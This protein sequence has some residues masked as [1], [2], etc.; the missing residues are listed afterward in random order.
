MLFIANPIYEY[1]SFLGLHLI[2]LLNTYLLGLR[3]DLATNRHE[4]QPTSRAFVIERLLLYTTTS[5][6]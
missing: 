5:E 6:T 2:K 3:F 1:P 4:Y